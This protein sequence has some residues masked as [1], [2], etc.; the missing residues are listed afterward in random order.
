MLYVVIPK[1][2]RSMN[3]MDATYLDIRSAH[4]CVWPVEQKRE[5]GMAASSTIFNV[6]RSR[7]SESQFAHMQILAR[8]H[9]RKNAQL[10]LEW[11]ILSEW[12]N[13]QARS[14]VFSQL[15]GEKD[16]EKEGRKEKHRTWGIEALELIHPSFG[17]LTCEIHCSI[18]THL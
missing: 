4:G 16:G 5:T 9:K 15:E 2:W 10:R 12:V 1:S 13:Q 11:V 7:N 14:K 6:G 3:V 17:K 8:S 18:L